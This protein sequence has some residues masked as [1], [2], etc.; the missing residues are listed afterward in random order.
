MNKSFDTVVINSSENFWSSIKELFLYKHLLYF[1]V[2]RDIQSIYRQTVLG[3][4]WAFVGPLFTMLLYTS[5]FGY[6]VKIPSEGLP[7]PIFVFSAL[8]AWNY[9]SGC[10]TGGA[11]S[12]LN[13][14]SILTK[15][16]FPR[17]LLPL[18]SIFSGLVNL[19]ISLIALVIL[20][21]VY[22]IPL[23][24]NAIFIPVF[25]LISISFSLGLS[26][27]LSP[28]NARFRDV[29][30]LLPYLITFG[31]YLTPVIYPLSLAKD[32]Y[33]QLLNLNP[34]THVVEGFRWAVTGVGQ[35]PF[36][37]SLCISVL[38]CIML[39]IF[40]IYFFQKSE[41]TVADSI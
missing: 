34:M 29:A 22:R 5:I 8:V 6:V 38:L 40:G 23:N 12:L 26:L 4:L 21:V 20:M 41:Q 25:L 1:F 13:N 18:I 7:Y 30:Q 3:F 16:Y 11:N 9:F 32:P 35:N 28:L 33:I 31:L 37:F 17:I 2:I 27:I 19:F 10:L 14:S 24:V 15:V 39:L 36:N